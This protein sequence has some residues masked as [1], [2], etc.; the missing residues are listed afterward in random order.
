MGLR[1]EH[2]NLVKVGHE[3]S[4]CVGVQAVGREP[5]SDLREPDL[6]DHDELEEDKLSLP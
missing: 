1:R 3:K 6:K 4:G 5:L 2:F